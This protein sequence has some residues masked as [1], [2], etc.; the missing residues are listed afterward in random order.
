MRRTLAAAVTFTILGGTAGGAQGEG[1]PLADFQGRCIL[2]AGEVGLDPGD[3]QR[4]L[5]RLWAHAEAHGWQWEWDGPDFVLPAHSARCSNEVLDSI[6]SS[7]RKLDGGLRGSVVI[8]LASHALERNGRVDDA[9][10]LLGEAREAARA[11]GEGRRSKDDVSRLSEHAARLAAHAERWQ[12]AIEFAQEWT[13]TSWCGNCSSSQT[14]RQRVL[15]ARSLY[16]L[17][18]FEDAIA[19]VRD[20]VASEWTRDVRLIEIWIDCELAL[21]RASR[22]EDAIGPIRAAVTDGDWFCD[23]ALESWKVARAPRETQIEQLDDL[24]QWHS[25]IALPLILSLDA[26]QIT[27]AMSAFDVVDGRFRHHALAGLLADVGYP[28][29]EDALGRAGQAH[30]SVLGYVEGKKRWT[31]LSRSRR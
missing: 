2:T 19:V 23:R 11:A 26:D 7:T 10:A 12:S 20:S 16:E 6:A 29:V 9:L 4:V 24:A 28:Q 13:S 21:E 30:D 22:A 15:V 8:R 5:E 3:A 25:E 14:C 18:R 27:L 17:G 31:A 1:E